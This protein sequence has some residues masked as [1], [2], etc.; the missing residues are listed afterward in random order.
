MRSYMYAHHQEESTLNN[1]K[2]LQKSIIVRN[3]QVQA[4]IIKMADEDD[5][6]SY[7]ETL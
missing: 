2:Y 4:G 7:G 3:I 6:A 5:V 1:R